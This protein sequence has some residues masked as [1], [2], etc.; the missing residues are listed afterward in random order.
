M[1]WFT[2][3]ARRLFDTTPH[4]DLTLDDQSDKTL[5]VDENADTEARTRRRSKSARCPTPGDSSMV[6]RARPLNEAIDPL[7]VP[8][9]PFPF[10]FRGTHI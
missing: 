9:R 1:E 5:L 8:P 3:T 7:F 6:L 10:S 2:T 4:L